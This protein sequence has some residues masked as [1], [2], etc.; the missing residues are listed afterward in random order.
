MKRIFVIVFSLLLGLSSCMADGKKEF[1]AVSDVPAAGQQI[2]N[3]FFSDCKVA[4]VIKETELFEIEYDVRFE[5]GMEIVFN[6]EGGW[7]KIDCRRASVPDALVPSEI[8]GKTRSLF[9]ESRIVEIEVDGKGYDVEL[10]S[11]LDL[12]FDKRFRMK[13]DD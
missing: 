2:L 5:G 10:S 11:G 8:L 7:K 12:K 6:A 13:I 3:S 9:P 4:A 1:V